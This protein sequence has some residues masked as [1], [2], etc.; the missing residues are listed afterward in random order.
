MISF[1][2]NNFSSSQEAQEPELNN[3]ILELEKENQELRQKLLL[4]EVTD[5][6]KKR[7]SNWVSNGFKIAL[8][9]LAIMGVTTVTALKSLYDNVEKSATQVGKEEAIKVA[10]SQQLKDI[11]QNQAVIQ[12][13][14][15]ITKKER[16]IIDQVVAQLMSDKEFQGRIQSTVITTVKDQQSFK[17]KSYYVVVGS[18]LKEQPLEYEKTQA[19][20][21]GFNIKACPT[22][23]GTRNVLVITRGTTN[24]NFLLPLSDAIEI[25]KLAIAKVKLFKDNQAY[26][27]QQSEA[28]FNCPKS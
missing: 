16:V 19:Q 12:V 13:K 22:H 18:D 26:I 9:V 10:N 20:Q 8:S 24:T 1:S 11:V 17:N 21:N 7:I 23:N 25:Q 14:E 6:A 4:D 15:Q 3:K 2:E 27:L 28:F 5:E